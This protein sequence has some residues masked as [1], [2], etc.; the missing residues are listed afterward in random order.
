MAA[1]QSSGYAESQRGAWLSIGAYLGLTALKLGVGVWTGSTALYSD[2]L[3]NSTDILASAAVLLGL[4]IAGR[5]ADEDHR[6][7]H[8]KAETIASVVAG[9]IMGA[10]GVTAGWN[11]IERVWSGV[12][13]VPSPL[14]AGV[15]LLAAGVMWA[16]YRFNRKLAE[17]TGAKSLMAAA[18]DNRSDAFTSLGT[19]AAVVAGWLGWTWAD[20]IIGLFI[21]GIILRTAWEVGAEAAH[22]LMDGFSPEELASI[23]ERVASVTGVRRVL[24]LR[25]RHIGMEV[26][27]EVTIGV[28]P[29][30]TIVE[31]HEVSH[32]VEEAL[33]GWSGI[34]HV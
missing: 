26:A 19:V 28:A 16:V 20:P 27:V 10:I 15:G 21:A 22:A 18:Y 5:P 3:N 31:A 33:L 6:Y 2:G 4:R 24:S 32:L 23:Q 17:R 13:V 11:A 34:E 25:A 7:G 8:A 9:L 29:S 14:T 1:R 30:L 12:H